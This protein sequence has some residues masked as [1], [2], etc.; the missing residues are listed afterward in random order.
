MEHNLFPDFR[1]SE[2]VAQKLTRV[3]RFTFVWF[4]ISLCRI[5]EISVLCSI[6]KHPR[7]ACKDLLFVWRCRGRG[8]TTSNRLGL[9]LIDRGSFFRALGF[10]LSFIPSHHH[11]RSIL[12][13][14]VTIIITI[15]SH[16][17]LLQRVQ[18]SQAS[19]ALLLALV[20]SRTSPGIRGHL[21]CTPVFRHSRSSGWVA[22]SL[23]ILANLKDT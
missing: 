10:N 5:L 11:D 22:I 2:S 23:G 9:D 18:S 1:N 12:S 6:H 21:R 8:L 7:R 4:C 17:R 15:V 16:R 3:P 13:T 19:Q 14:I 20:H